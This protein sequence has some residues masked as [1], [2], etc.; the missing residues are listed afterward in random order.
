[1]ALDIFL[2]LFVTMGSKALVFI[3]LVLWITRKTEL[4]EAREREEAWDSGWSL[5]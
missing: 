3:G 2:L 4:E 1:M 5:R